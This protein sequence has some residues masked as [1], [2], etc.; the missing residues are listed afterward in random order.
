MA[1][2][3][4]LVNAAAVIAAG[5]LGLIL[6]KGIQKRFQDIVTKAIGLAVIFIGISGTLSEILVIEKGEITTQ[7][8]MMLIISL[9][10]GA[11]LGEWIDLEGY[12]E[13]FGGWLKHKARSDGD[14]LFI[15]G[16]VVTSLTICI[17]AMAVVGALNDGLTGDASM[18]YTKAILDFIIVIIFAS[19]YGAGVIFSVIPLVVFQGSIT[20]LARFIAPYLTGEVIGNLSMVGSVLIFCVGLNLTFKAGL[21]IAN[22]LPALLVAVLFTLIL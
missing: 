14:S 15:E 18:L 5:I 6:K 22:L 7:G 12:A 17:G 20:I 21:K 19:T 2:V 8:S 1:G 11:L 16:F 13:K 3:G 10:A 9:V 4:T